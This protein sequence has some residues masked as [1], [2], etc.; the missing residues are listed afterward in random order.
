VSGGGEPGHVTTGLGDDHLSGALPHPR[1]GLQALD[2]AGERAH[3]FLDP[4]RELLNRRGELV[5]AVQVQ[6]AQ[7][8]VVLAEVPPQRLDQLG[9]LGAH[10]GVRQLGQHPGI[11]FPGDQ[12]RQHRP[13][14]LAQDVRRDAGQ[15]DP[16]VFQFLLQP[17]GLPGAFSGQGGAVTGQIP[18]VPDRFGGHERGPQQPT[19]AHLT[20]PRRVGHIGLTAGQ[21]LGVRGVDQHDVQFVFQQVERP[22]PVVPGRLHHHQRDLFGHQPVPQLQQGVGGGGEGADL[23]ATRPPPP[24]VRC[25]HA[26]FEFLLPDVQRRTPLVQDVH[27]TLRIDHRYWPG[28]PSGGITGLKRI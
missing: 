22:T 28:A 20:Q 26:S 23:L 24:R 8:R 11:P 16:G 25:P 14:G 21:S 4:G 10:P 13:P 5:D 3:L 6:L 19:L 27:T 9:D 1:D 17:V 2:L 7:E 15:F 12:R 18:Q